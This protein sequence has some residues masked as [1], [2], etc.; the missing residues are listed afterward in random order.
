MLEFLTPFP[1]TFRKRAPPPFCCAVL[2]CNQKHFLHF[3]YFMVHFR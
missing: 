3:W 2:H 1:K